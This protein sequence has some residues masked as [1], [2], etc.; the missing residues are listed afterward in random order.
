MNFPFL[1]KKKFD[2]TDI[3]SRDSKWVIEND[4]M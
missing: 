2:F 1:H 3:E 4:S